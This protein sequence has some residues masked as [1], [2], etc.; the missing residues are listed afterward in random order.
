MYNLVRP[1]ASQLRSTMQTGEQ[2]VYNVGPWTIPRKS[3]PSM[4][5]NEG[6]LFRK[7]VLT[8]AA[9]L[10]RR[11]RGEGR[12]WFYCLMRS[13]K[14][15]RDATMRGEEQPVTVCLPAGEIPSE[16]IKNMIATYN[17]DKE[18]VL[19]VTAPDHSFAALV[20]LHD[21]IYDDVGGAPVKAARVT[22]GI[23][24]GSFFSN[25]FRV[26]ASCQQG[27]SR[28]FRCSKCK[29]VVYCS[30]KCQKAHWPTHKTTCNT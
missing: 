17:T 5:G 21:T 12:G 1:F 20:P 6:E 8:M 13:K 27:S 25:M 3:S 23:H 28:M 19:W 7:V 2:L 14:A 9:T 4:V 22:T 15:L 29:C 16:G 26:C 24:E 30:S 11:P 18:F 10:Q